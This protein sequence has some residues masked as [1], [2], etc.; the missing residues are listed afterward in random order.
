M[1][2]SPPSYRPLSPHYDHADT[3]LKRKLFPFT[4]ILISVWMV[5]VFGLLWLLERAVRKGMRSVDPS[6]FLTT[7]PDLLL[8][9]FAQAHVAITG[10]HLTRLGASCLLYPSTAPRTW[11]DLFWMADHGWEGPVGMV[12]TTLDSIRTRSRASFTFIIFAT[13]CAIGLLTPVALSRAYEIKQ[14]VLMNSIDI[15]PS[16]TNFKKMQ[17]VEGYT[18]VGVSM[19]SWATGTSVADIYNTSLFLPQGV[20]QTATFQPREFFFAGDIHN[21]T[22]VLPGVH[23]KGSCAPIDIGS[24]GLDTSNVTT[25]WAPFCR[26]RIPQFVGDATGQDFGSTAGFSH[27]ELRLCSNGTWDFAL[28][29][30]SDKAQSENTGYAYYDYSLSDNSSNKGLI[31]CNSTLTTGT[32]AV[33]GLN[34]T[35]AGFTRHT[36]YNA[37]DSTG[38]E[39]LLDPMY[40][41]FYMLALDKNREDSFRRGSLMRGLGFQHRQDVGANVEVAPLTPEN[42]SESL[43]G[44]VAH[45]TSAIA[46][47]SRDNTVTYPAQ[48]PIPVAIYTRDL[49]F[50]IIA[51]GL[52]IVWFIL[53]AGT[54]SW[55][56]RRTF[57]AGLD[58][59]VAAQLIFREKAL[60][61]GL[62]IGE[63]GDNNRLTA[64]FRAL[65]SSRYRESS[66]TDSLYK[67]RG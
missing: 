29:R 44:S 17:H 13:T 56:F 63:M 28:G 45:Y 18:Q 38:G 54:T 6:W 52:L 47:L 14:V 2:S 27:F 62:P 50:A 30:S 60:L 8:T 46:V 40:A 21:A 10:M 51:Y 57:S 9:V 37:S 41:A 33:S 23:L 61:E 66:E 1:K 43:W 22:A 19:G 59:Y 35:F 24:S 39:P 67:S 42:I 26:S 55:S 48:V 12:T 25:S 32:A 64:P 3:S 20:S 7:L 36:L 65:T 11:Q 58:S 49:P 15:Q 31:Q 5:Y 16:T 4:L 53:V 34:R